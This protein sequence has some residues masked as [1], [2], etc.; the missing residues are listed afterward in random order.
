MPLSLRS[1]R[2]Y[3]EPLWRFLFFCWI[4]SAAEVCFFRFLSLHPFLLVLFLFIVWR[5]DGV[6]VRGDG[7]L[8]HSLWLWPPCA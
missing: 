3:S 5:G 6:L 7:V 1:L 4:V 2:D 8:G